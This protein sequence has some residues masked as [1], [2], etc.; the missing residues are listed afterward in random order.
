MAVDT[1]NAL[2]LLIPIILIVSMLII[3]VRWIFTDE[4]QTT[5][6][7]RRTAMGGVIGLAFSGILI[8][9]VMPMAINEL[10]DQANNLVIDQNTTYTINA[11]ETE[12]YQCVTWLTDATLQLNEGSTLMV[13]EV[14]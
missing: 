4:I 1:T 10:R 9:N 2:L 11:G 6:L 7:N 5:N 8:A 13:S 3:L 14:V 12:T